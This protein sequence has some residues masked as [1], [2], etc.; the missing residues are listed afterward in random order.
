MYSTIYL[1]R[2]GETDWNLNGRWQGHAD[3]P[4]NPLGLRQAQLV[5]RRFLS[6]QLPVDALYSSDLDR[7][8]R[9]A[10]AIGEAVQLEV[11]PLPELR[12]I[13]V[14]R[15]SGLTY[16]EIRVHYP[17]EIAMIEQGHD[18][19][20]GGGESLTLLRRRVVAAI[21]SL[22][23]R[24]PQATLAIVTH[25]GCI[26][27][28]L[29]HADDR[30]D[31]DHHGYLHIGNTSISTLQIGRAGWRTIQTNDMRHLEEQ[32][33]PELASTPPDDAELPAL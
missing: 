6:E 14:G 17:D 27:M 1:I 8:Y 33:D 5:A 24:H 10:R 2:H 23:A 30:S 32:H 19:P 22:V 31:L 12:E 26:R 21:E 7:A 20:R 15:W 25:G 16:E 29:A 9:T 3:V 11:Q 13:D 4:L 18:I 28:L